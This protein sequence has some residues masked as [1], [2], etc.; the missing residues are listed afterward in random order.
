MA[1]QNG[2]VIGSNAY[3]DVESS[4]ADLPEVTAND[5]DKYLHTNSSTGN[6][7]WS[8]FNVPSGLLQYSEE[9]LSAS[10][11]DLYSMIQSGIIPYYILPFEEDGVIF[12]WVMRLGY[13]C[14]E[15]GIYIAKFMSASPSSGTQVQTEYFEASDD[16]SNMI[17][18]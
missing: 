10:Y 2:Y 11:S 14:V 12:N 8:S 16:T 3:V 7:E 4:G 9:T 1:I 13:L 5:K 6:L 18:D 15:D 17:L